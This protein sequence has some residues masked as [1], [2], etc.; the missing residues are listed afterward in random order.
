MNHADDIQ[1]DAEGV[2][3]SCLWDAEKDATLPAVERLRL[4]DRTRQRWDGYGVIS[5]ALRGQ[6][7][8][9]AD[10]VR[11]ASVMAHVAQAAVSPASPDRL[12]NAANDTVWRWKWVAG[13]CAATAVS[14]L[15]W[16][17]WQ[18][19]AASRA[20]AELARVQAVEVVKV[21]SDDG[22]RMLR[23]P[24]L[25]ALLAEHRQHAGLSAVQLSSGFL[26]NATYEWPVKR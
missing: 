19:A 6:A 5:S 15:S 23:H 16:G 22:G 4:D 25:E 21:S 2:A 3:L 8:P 10:A 26:R 24:E 1:D 11:V 9:P 13:V 7:L 12:V 20:G 17:V 14:A 18:G